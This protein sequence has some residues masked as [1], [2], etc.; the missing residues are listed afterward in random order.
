MASERGLG[1]LTVELGQRTSES[2]QSR[3]CDRITV[4]AEVIWDHRFREHEPGEIMDI[5]PRGLFM[6]ASAGLPDDLQVGDIVW[7][8][9]WCGDESLSFSATVRWR[10]F[11]VRHQR[12]GIGV[13]FKEPSVIPANVLQRFIARHS[14]PAPS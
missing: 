8:A 10:G 13:E 3:S 1:P 12:S 2:G 6:S 11:S 14:L 5:S 7:G 9:F 4:L